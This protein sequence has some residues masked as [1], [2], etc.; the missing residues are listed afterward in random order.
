MAKDNARNWD[1][2]HQ[3]AQ[4]WV[5]AQRIAYPSLKRGYSKV[6][7]DKITGNRCWKTNTV[8]KT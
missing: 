2:Q 6:H 3:F 4:N 1:S 5:H 8:T 7:I